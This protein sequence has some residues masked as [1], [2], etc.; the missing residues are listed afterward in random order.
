MKAKSQYLVDFKLSSSEKLAYYKRSCRGALFG[1]QGRYF[2]KFLAINFGGLGDEVLFLPTLKT[3]RKA[4]P[5]WHITLLTEPRARSIAQLSPQLIDENICF[6]IKKKPLTAFDLIRLIALLRRGKYDIVL[7]SGSSARVSILLF[8]SG[9][10]TR[11]GYDSGAL[12]RMLLSKTAVLN[13]NQYAAHMYEGLVSGL[14]LSPS[15]EAPE[16][17]ASGASLQKMQEFLDAER[18]IE[19]ASAAEKLP[20]LVLIHPGTSRLAIEKGIIKTWPV[21]NWA[22]LIANLLNENIDV[23]ICGGPDDEASIS[24]LSAALASTAADGLATKRG[25]LIN[26]YGK[27]ASISDLAALMQICDLVVCVDSAP[28]HIA[29]ALNK[30]LLALF[31]PTEVEKLLLT[32]PEKIALRESNTDSEAGQEPGNTSVSDGALTGSCE[33]GVRIPLDTV[34]RTVL[35]LLSLSSSP[36]S[37][38]ESLQG[39]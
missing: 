32:S 6:D 14:G 3:I 34:Y 4:H 24:S 8:L 29:A 25:R 9:I 37:S 20:P 18:A 13:K 7:S 5:D 26:A 17:F 27:T 12:S 36:N 39:H 23:L 33:P 2:M 11:I 28:M 31:G 16:L 19:T 1:A 38:Q 22:A 15:N 30:K 10:K 21:K 35:D